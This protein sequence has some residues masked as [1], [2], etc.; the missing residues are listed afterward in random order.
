MNS[1]VY[2]L[3]ASNVDSAEI[4]DGRA[5]ISEKVVAEV[6]RNITEC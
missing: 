1:D 5:V 3:I 6:W 2:V 4:N